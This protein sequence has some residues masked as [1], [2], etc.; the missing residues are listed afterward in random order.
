MKGAI[1]R[2][3]SEQSDTASA[4]SE[5]I[6]TR[7]ARRYAAEEERGDTLFVS[8]RRR[9]RWLP[10]AIRPERAQRVKHQTG[11]RNDWGALFVGMEELTRHVVRSRTAQVYGVASCLMRSHFASVA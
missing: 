11:I 1:L 6:K 10:S 4:E 2:E 8:E 5:A 9:S 7:I 3:R